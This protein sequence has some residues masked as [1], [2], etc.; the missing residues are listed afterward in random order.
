[1]LAKCSV[2]KKT[3]ILKALVLCCQALVFLCRLKKR[4]FSVKQF[5]KC[6]YL[7]FNHLQFTKKLFRVPIGLFTSNLFT[8]FLACLPKFQSIYYGLNYII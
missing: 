2:E 4:F 8:K 7:I 6:K 1:M 5:R 3:D